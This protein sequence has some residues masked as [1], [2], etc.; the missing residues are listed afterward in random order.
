[1]RVMRERR[2]PGV[3]YERGA[4]LGAEMSGIPGDRAQRVSGDVEQQAVDDPFVIPGDGADGCGKREDDVEVLD[5]QQVGLACLQPAVCGTGLALWAMPVPTCNGVN[6][7]TC[8]MGSFVLWG[9]EFP[10]RARSELRARLA[11]H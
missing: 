10:E 7:I 4:D 1:M 9:E 5:R 2:A 6:S 8:L 3:Q 11:L